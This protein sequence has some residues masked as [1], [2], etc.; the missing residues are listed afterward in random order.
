M[1]LNKP[2]GKNSNELMTE[3]D[4]AMIVARDSIRAYAPNEE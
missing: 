2:A 4:R 3:L 1:S